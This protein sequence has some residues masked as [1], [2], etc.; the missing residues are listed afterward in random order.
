M[1]WDNEKDS[2]GAQRWKNGLFL[3]IWA[4]NETRDAILPW[5]ALVMLIML[6]LGVLI[7][8]LTS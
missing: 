2:D 3:K 6:G 4:K 8:L 5:I 1:F 7:R